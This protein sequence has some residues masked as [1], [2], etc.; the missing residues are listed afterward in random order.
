MQTIPPPSLTPSAASSPTAKQI[1]VT[2]ALLTLSNAEPTNILTIRIDI[3]DKMAEFL[4]LII[5]YLFSKKYVRQSGLKRSL[6]KQ[7]LI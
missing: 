3:K 5:P 6:T 1:H 4:K 7:N 2:T